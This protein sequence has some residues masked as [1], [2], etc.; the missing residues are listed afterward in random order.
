MRFACGS[1]IGGRDGLGR[2]GIVGGRGGARVVRLFGDV[3]VDLEG[4]SEDELK[5]WCSRVIDAAVVP[6]KEMGGTAGEARRGR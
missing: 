4:L 3:P 2:S 1:R 5:D 6:A